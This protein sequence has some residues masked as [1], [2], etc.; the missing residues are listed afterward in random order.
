MNKFKDNVAMITGA[1]SG[2]G[3]AIAEKCLE[4]EMALVLAWDRLITYTGNISCLFHM[5]FTN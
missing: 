5:P 2:I 3:K 1:A 4:Y